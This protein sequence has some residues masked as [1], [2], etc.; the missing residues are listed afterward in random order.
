MAVHNAKYSVSAMMLHWTIALL[1]AYNY[2]LGL[3]TEDSAAKA[4]LFAI[5][6]LHKSVGILVLLLTLARIWIRVTRPKPAMLS[7][8]GW[9][10][11]ISSLVHIAF[12]IIMVGLPVTGWI[13]VSTS[14]IKVPTMIFGVIP[15]PDLPLDGLAPWIG[16]PTVDAHELIANAALAL[17]VLHLVGVVRHQFALR[18]NVV[19]RM[20]PVAR[21]G[22]AF[23]MLAV[24]LLGGTFLLGRYGPPQMAAVPPSLVIDAQPC[25]PPAAADKAAEPVKENGAI[26]P[27]TDQPA[28]SALPGE[29]ADAKRPVDEWTVQP[30]GRLGF[31]VTVNGEQVNGQ[32]GRWDS[33]IAFDPAR[34]ELAAI[35][36]RIGLATATTGDGQRDA[37]LQEG[38]FFD[39]A[40]QPT[41]RFKST[42]V[43][44][45]GNDRYAARGL[46]T[47]K[48]AA[49]PATI[50]FLLRIS[51]DTAQVSGGTAIRRNDF[52]VGVG[53]WAGD[54][55]ISHKVDVAF[56]FSARRKVGVMVP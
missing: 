29:A 36:V 15:W 17:V 13:I 47:I 39:T 46:L 18:D 14:D 3:K 52:L 55:A 56:N 33:S 1:L 11:T 10:K 40:S 23:L 50:T 5:Y 27:A 45:L 51:G 35:D 28:A 16:K 12:Y 43:R 22:A 24:A 25:S 48:G 26:Q 21:H 32:F 30:G 53:Q 44:A 20:A 41:A 37:M 9:A 8:D 49:H 38:D 54:D 34:P 19:S 7:D 31:A 2:G 6:Q 4:D 42:Y